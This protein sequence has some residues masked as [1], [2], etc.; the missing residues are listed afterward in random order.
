M[1]IPPTPDLATLRQMPAFG[2]L[3]EA[4][5]VCLALFEQS[6][7][8]EIEALLGLLCCQRGDVEAGRRHLAAV[9][10]RA[11]PLSAAVLTDL[12]GIHILLNEPVEAIAW[13]EQALTLTPDDP[14]ARTRRGLVALQT[15]RWNLAIADFEYGLQH[16]PASRQGA[17]HANLGRAWLGIGQPEQALAEVQRARTALTLPDPWPL[18]RLEIDALIALRHWDDAEQAIHRAVAVGLEPRR[19]LPVHAF[20]LA[21]RDRHDDAEHEVRK[22]LERYP[23]EPELWLLLAELTEVRGRFGAALNSL[24]RALALEPDNPELWLRKA[25]L[26]RR[27][28]NP[29]G[30][31]EAAARALALTQN[32]SGQQRALALAAAAEVED[33][34]NLAEGYYRRALE[35]FDDC[36]AAR[37]GLGRLLLQWGRVDEAEAEFARVKAHHPVAGYSALISARHFPDDP[38]LLARI[39]RL[40]HSPGLEGSVRTGLLF[41]LASSHEH[42]KDYPKAFACAELANRASRKHLPYDAA[43]HRA[44]IQAIK[45]TFSRDFFAR[46][47]GFGHP[48]TLPVFVLG[49]PRSGTTLVEQII[50]GHSAI[51]GAGEIGCL[52]PVIHSMVRWEMRSGSGLGWPG[53]VTDLTAREV[54]GYADKVLEQLG[55]HQDGVRHVVDKLPHN[56][57]NIGLIRLLFPEAPIIHVLREPRDVAISNFFTDYQAKFGGMGFAYDLT[58]LG[59]HLVDYQDLMAH[60]DQV[61][62]RPI[63]TVCYESV[64]ENVEAAARTLLDY[65]GVAWEAGVLDF[66]HLERPVKTASVWQVRQ[67]VYQTSKAKWR[68]YAEFLG[69]LEAALAEPLPVVV[70]TTETDPLPPGLFFE[71]MEQLKTGQAGA[72][73]QTFARI[74]ARHPGHAAAT[75]FRGM[76]CYQ[77]GRLDEALQLVRDSIALHPGHPDWARNRALVEAALRRHKQTPG[78]A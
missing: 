68:R 4:H 56:F 72:A 50:A 78:G 45:T 70:A 37:L 15:G 60:W 64:V 54:K 14:A 52:N 17:L 55:H 27:L 47:A 35:Q 5:A 3:A 11:E 19:L 40:A 59:R 46:R 51:H 49:M 74:L 8:V 29:A 76:A 39:D 77:Q 21:A 23:D 43:T 65:I 22:G 30:A 44:R 34:E 31:R 63:L 58:D 42:R 6:P 24:E 32:H 26:G 53:C 38:E 57:E 66:Q 20:V 13:L 61:L 71:G 62:P 2:Q 12:A 73:E 7:S 1:N 25:H 69:P 16:L 28:F 10:A 48:A 75:H 9:K 18:Y 41:N 33:D 67:P 36:V